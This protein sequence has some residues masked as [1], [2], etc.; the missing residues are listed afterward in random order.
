MCQH[1]VENTRLMIV[2]PASVWE[3]ETK[4]LLASAVSQ[5]Q[6]CKPQ[7]FRCNRRISSAWLCRVGYKNQS[8]RNS[9]A[10]LGPTMRLVLQ[11]HNPPVFWPA[12]TDKLRQDNWHTLRQHLPQE[13]ESWWCR[14]ASHTHT[15]WL[16]HAA[17]QC[18]Q[19]LMEIIS[20]LILSFHPDLL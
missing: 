17:F 20:I 6:T 3:Q 4:H 16:A 14:H 2:L 5:V 12:S 7:C 9:P 15:K 18:R 11:V 13:T 19:K 1:V 10:G 8:W